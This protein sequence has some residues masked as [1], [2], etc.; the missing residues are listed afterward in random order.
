MCYHLV[1]KIINRYC[2]MGNSWV[3]VTCAL[4]PEV[5]LRVLYL[6]YCIKVDTP[7][8]YHSHLTLLWQTNASLLTL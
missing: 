6:L 8:K 7:T 2:P 4:I 3:Y 1:S 5:T